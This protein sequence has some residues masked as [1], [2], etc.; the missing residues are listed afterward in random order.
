MSEPPPM[1][2]ARA[3]W[4]P[5]QFAHIV[6]WQAAP[7]V[8]PLTC[9]FDGCRTVLAVTTRGLECPNCD[10][11][12]TWV[13]GVVAEH[14]PPPDPVPGLNARAA[15]EY[16]TD[17]V[18]PPPAGA[19]GDFRPFGPPPRQITAER[20]AA[21]TIAIRLMEMHL[22]MMTPGGAGRDSLAWTVAIGR[23]KTLKDLLAE[24]QATQPAQ[25][26]VD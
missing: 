24:L 18:K 1:P 17:D 2:E 23:V 19:P 3:P 11:R 8:H 15:A 21:L 7:W 14:G 22:E 10:Y 4:T 6:E 20:V 12:Q 9:A 5:T 26:S 16:T 13:P 25:P